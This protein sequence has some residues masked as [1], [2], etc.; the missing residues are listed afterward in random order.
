MAEERVQRR[1]AAILAADVV[2]YSR[3]MELDEAGTMATLKTRQKEVV[4]PL[5]VRHQGRI[6]KVTGD[7][8]L[9]EFGS[10]VNAVQCAVELQHRMAASNGDLPKARHIILRVG[11]N[12]G[13]VMVEGGDLYGDAVN[14][15]AR[16]ES[17]AEPGGILVSGAVH[18]YA[19][20]KIGA[21]FEDLGAR[22]VRNIVD[23][24]RV[25]RVVG[26]P[27]GEVGATR[28]TNDKPSIAVLPFVNMSG[29]AE[30]E[31]F[32]DGITED[33]ITELSRFNSLFVIARNSSFQFKDQSC[34]VREVGRKLGVAFIV[35][36]S[37]RKSGGRI[38][39][40]AQL[41]DT[42]TGKHLW[43]ERYDRALEDIFDIQV[44]LAR[45][46]AA[47]VPGKLDRSA[48]QTARRK[49]LDDL[50]AYDHFLRAK[51]FLD[52]DFGSSE[53]LAHLNE[54]I[55]IDPAFA[56][57]HATL[58]DYYCYN[59][60]LTGV[61]TEDTAKQALQSAERALELDPTDPVI[62]AI[63][64]EVYLVFG[65]HDLARRHNELALKL[66]ENDITVMT[67][68]AGNASHLGEHD[69][70]L[71]LLDRCLRH[72]PLYGD[73]FRHAY[74]HIYYTV[75]RYQDALDFLDGDSTRSRH[76]VQ[77]V[78]KPV[79]LPREPQ[80]CCGVENRRKPE[81]GGRSPPRSPVGVSHLMRSTRTVTGP[82]RSKIETSPVTWP[83]M[84]IP[85]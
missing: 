74:F 79:S 59:H 16:L 26:T 82:G 51:W 40:T 25:Y 11:V 10:A 14:I 45:E 50:T 18:D 5:I 47:V 81:I 83:R 28:I 67:Y 77:P 30:Q 84:M 15:A 22:N 35:E 38:R 6:F 8:I 62:H 21:A 73:A 3:L 41:V 29:D 76:M 58:A 36:G 66:N 46:I 43:A 20:N 44:E 39:V 75:K 9:V 33:I 24:V 55:R 64:A 54:S 23:P 42:D 7:G 4:E 80:T 1:L 34:G 72:D 49:K 52:R 48:I 32:A 17:M 27:A 53:G 69:R 13:D 71:D 2:G 85:G 61:L 57:A 12:L 37:V 65:K 68:A 78:T 63:V 31:Y 70:A 56:R 19:K 60:M